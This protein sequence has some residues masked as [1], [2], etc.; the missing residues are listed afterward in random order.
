MEGIHVFKHK[1]ALESDKARRSEPHRAASFHSLQSDL[2]ANQSRVLAM[3]H[4]HG[5]RA[6]L[7]MIARGRAA[8]AQRAPQIGWNQQNGKPTTGPNHGET[9]VPVDS[10]DPKLGGARRIPVR[11]L[12]FGTDHSDPS[13]EDWQGNKVSDVTKET[14]KEKQ[15]IVIIPD[16]LDVSQPVGVLLHLQGL[17]VGYR[18]QGG[19]VEDV[20]FARIEQQLRAS[21]R[22]MIAI[23]PQAALPDKRP[24]APDFGDVYRDNLI[25]DVFDFLTQQKLW[26]T[27]PQPD[28]KSPVRGP[29]VYSAYSGGGFAATAILNN[30]I[31]GKGAKTGDINPANMAGVILFDSIHNDDQVKQVNDWLAAQ[32]NH[33]LEQLNNVAKKTTDP[34]QRE[35]DQLQYLTTSMRFRGI[36]S[37]TSKDY[38]AKNYVKVKAA[39][40]AW[41]ASQKDT[42]VKIT[43]PGVI[44]NLTANYQVIDTGHADH[45]TVISQGDPLKNALTDMPA[46]GSTTAK[47][48]S[49]A[50]QVPV[51][52]NTQQTPNTQRKAR[53]QRQP[54][55]DP[56][57]N[58]GTTNQSAATTEQALSD[59]AI[60]LA[61][62]GGTRLQPD[63]IRNRLQTRSTDTALAA[64]FSQLLIQITLQEMVPFGSIMAVDIAA[65]TLIKFL[66]QQF[67]QAPKAS[68]LDLLARGQSYRNRKWD[69]L[70]YPGHAD[71]EAEG[72]HEDE[73]RQMIGDL[74]AIEGERRPNTGTTAVVQESEF[75]SDERLRT[76]IVKQLRTVPD[77]PADPVKRARAV[78]QSDQRLNDKA[79]TDFLRMRQDADN[80]G[81]DL[82]IVDGYRTPA[83][84]KAHAEGQNPNA[85]ASYSSH[86]L[87]L[88]MDLQMSHGRQQYEETTTR[89]MQNV[90]DMH[91]APAHKWMFLHGPDYGWFPWHSEPWH[92][93]YNPTG[94][95]DRFQADFQQWQV[96][97]PPA[98]AHRR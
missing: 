46:I 93:E 6:V 36:Y 77:L 12:K 53:I 49:G 63:Y 97:N 5:N 84:S 9:N 16:N 59:A 66:E 25:N 13:G 37:H 48:T 92:W 68:T 31:K 94:F 4:T 74:G 29:L 96:D 81:V 30:D 58:T 2:T 57:G 11:G 52:Q 14:A 60:R 44:A 17:T 27:K 83:T 15:A 98:P 87:G 76:Y 73:A 21:G 88:A 7:R 26:T 10:A 42:L 20:D 62:T 18:N 86:N 50:G 32:M 71:G 34:T 41:F 40:D 54:A 39:I 75:T 95:R 51:K 45:K 80:D 89:P 56:Q 67:I 22:N 35:K 70:D 43:T 28:T 24:S 85:I 91:Q 33:D 64:E 82:I 3:Q 38:Y 78:S 90:V 23:L 79:L 72:P 8:L 1:R 65:Q 61:Q 55:P 19:Q 47:Q 69:R